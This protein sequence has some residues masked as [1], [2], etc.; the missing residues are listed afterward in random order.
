V[1]HANNASATDP[2]VVSIF[3]WAEDIKI[4]VSTAD[5]PLTLAPQAGEETVGGRISGPMSALARIAG[6]MASIPTIGPFAMATGMVASGIGAAAKLF[7]F[8]RPTIETPVV[9]MRPDFQGNIA[10]TDRPEYVNKLTVD[11]SQEV[12]IDPSVT[13][14]NFGDELVIS[15]IAKKETYLT[16]FTWDYTQTA[17]TSLFWCAV[18]PNLV[19]LVP[20]F[21]VTRAVYPTALAFASLPFRYWR[22]T[23][24]FRFEVIASKF[25]KGRLRFMY[26]P[27]RVPVVTD[28][29]KNYQ[30]V[31]DLDSSTDLTV[32]VH[33]AVPQPILL[34]RTP[35]FTTVP[36][37]PVFAA[38]SVLTDNGG[39]YVYVLN[40]LSVP[41]QSLAAAS[42]LAYVNVYVS[43]G[44]DF[45]LCVPDDFNLTGY[46]NSAPFI[47]ASALE[48]DPSSG[49]ESNIWEIGEP[50]MSR[51]KSLVLFG[52]SY[53]SFRT[54]MKRYFQYLP[55]I[56]KSTAA[57]SY[58][59]IVAWIR[60][61][62]LAPGN[63][64]AGINSI[65]NLLGI[66]GNY[67]GNN[68]KYNLIN[69]LLGAFSGYRG[70]FRYKYQIN[71]ITSASNG[72]DAT[73]LVNRFT[74]NKHIAPA[75][76]VG[77]GASTMTNDN[78]A[79]IVRGDTTWNGSVL[80]QSGK[81]PLLEIEDP[82]FEKY[83]FCNPKMLYYNATTNYGGHALVTEMVS[84]S[85]N[86]A[87]VRSWVSTGEDFNLIYY[88]GP[89][90]LWTSAYY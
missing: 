7:G 3:A 13:G 35:S 77:Y 16:Q 21:T 55:M 26:D 75:A 84:A 65:A 78:A 58:D 4:S 27:R 61:L 72:L 1:L 39:L 74:T 42:C 43:A 69:H 62:P 32:K 18:T 30:N 17:D 50:D 57:S 88:T 12:T 83:K 10:Q 23:L 24:V 59:R 29:N 79:I 49:E 11:S 86:A 56:F 70:S 8:S 66:A 22:G 53:F 25:H 54:L 64:A 82:Y 52:E 73:W 90:Y 20:S 14:V 28:F 41:S 40:N 47:P 34:N 37:G 60:R 2:P 36:F 46:T 89:G 19:G 85:S 71:N 6:S 81:C 51:N 33:W 76:T 31:L 67:P 38:P 45:E 5:P 68:Y 9:P 80:L 87:F 48:L 15:N 63:D 44:D